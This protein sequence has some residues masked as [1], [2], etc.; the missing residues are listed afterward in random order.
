[1]W[2]DI[3]L[4]FVE[5]LY[6]WVNIAFSL[7]G[8]DNIIQSRG[9][10]FEIKLVDL[11]LSYLVLARKPALHGYQTILGQIQGIRGESE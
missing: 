9:G 6:V 10:P 8:L 5:P 3:N 4:F 2:Y 11:R 7:I 1:M